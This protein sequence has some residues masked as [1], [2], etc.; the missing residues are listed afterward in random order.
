MIAPKMQDA[1]TSAI[2]IFK[3]RVILI[4]ES[5]ICLTGKKKKITSEIKFW[6]K[7]ELIFELKYFNTLIL[8]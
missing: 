1:L 5:N 3:K 6:L 2:L 8:I 4:H 7:L